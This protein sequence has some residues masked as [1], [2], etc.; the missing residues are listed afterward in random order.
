MNV[1]SFEFDGLIFVKLNC[2]LLLLGFRTGVFDIFF[3]IL[4]ILSVKYELYS[5]SN[6]GAVSSSLIVFYYYWSMCIKH[7]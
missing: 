3:L 1:L 5:E 6:H 7:F 2:L 4:S